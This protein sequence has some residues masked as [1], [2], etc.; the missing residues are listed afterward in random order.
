VVKNSE[1]IPVPPHTSSWFGAQL[2]K[3]RDNFA[4][5]LKKQ[6]LRR[7]T[8]SWDF[9]NTVMNFEFYENVRNFLIP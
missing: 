8:G 6:D 9:V 3:Q 1:A 2:V 7:R 4:F 5:S